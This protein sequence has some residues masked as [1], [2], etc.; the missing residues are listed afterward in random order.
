MNTRTFFL[1]LFLAS[2]PP[3]VQATPIYDLSSRLG[4]GQIE[5]NAESGNDVSGVADFSYSAASAFV[6]GST[7]FT[8]VDINTVQWTIDSSAILTFM[9]TTDL[10]VPDF[11]TD[12]I[13]GLA[14]RNPAGGSMQSPCADN[15]VLIPAPIVMYCKKDITTGYSTNA[16]GRLE[17]K[18]HVAAPEPSILSL[19]LLGMVGTLGIRHRL[20]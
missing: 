7:T 11:G 15:T 12:I 8:E 20:L 17:V 2:F 18:L 9:L 16:G 13:V 10:K 6:G 19:L 1:C 3:F 4:T 14:M 5:F